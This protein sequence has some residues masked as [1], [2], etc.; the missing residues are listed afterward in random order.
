MPGF[1]RQLEADGAEF[2]RQRVHLGPF[3]G[4]NKFAT[5]PK[6]C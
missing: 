3:Q 6:P 1:S 4:D 5:S 2:L